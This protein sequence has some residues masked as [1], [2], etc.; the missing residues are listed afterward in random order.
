MIWISAKE[1][2]QL[3]PGTD[4]SDSDRLTVLE[5]LAEVAKRGYLFV[6]NDEACRDL[7][8]RSLRKA[9]EY[10]YLDFN[11][12]PQEKKISEMCVKAFGTSYAHQKEFKLG[13]EQLKGN[14]I[15]DIALIIDNFQDIGLLTMR[16]SKLA[17][18]FLRSIGRPPYEILLLCVGTIDS[19]KLLDQDEQLKSALIIHHIK[20]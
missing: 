3:F 8:V 9:I 1:L 2:K 12:E 11:A 15:T 16:E 19:V 14:R 18:A 20:S 5:S 13:I 4:P 6:S 17:L 10:H 7:A